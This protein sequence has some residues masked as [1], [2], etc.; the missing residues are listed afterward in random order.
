MQL[1]EI[2]SVV[3]APTGIVKVAVVVVDEDSPP[4][5]VV[6]AVR[7]CTAHVHPVGAVNP[8]I[9]TITLQVFAPNV[10]IPAVAPPVVEET[11]HPLVVN[12][13]PLETMPGSV[14]TPVPPFTVTNVVEPPLNTMLPAAPPPVAVPD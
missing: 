12:F 6:A 10:R 5:S 7:S 8:P 1:N 2:T 11:E 4:I 9:V 3:P 13:V 14:V